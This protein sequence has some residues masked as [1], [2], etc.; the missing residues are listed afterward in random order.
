MG[1]DGSCES[2]TSEREYAVT[3]IVR[4]VYVN[5]K[6]LVHYHARGGYCLTYGRNL[7]LRTKS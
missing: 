7:D 4:M 3:P 6:L 2:I 5:Y 1:R